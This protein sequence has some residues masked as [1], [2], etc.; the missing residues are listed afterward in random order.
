MEKHAC[1]V[2]WIC[3]IYT[4]TTAR[5]HLVDA[6]TAICTPAQAARIV[7]A[8][9][10]YIVDGANDRPVPFENMTPNLQSEVDRLRAERDRAIDLAQQ[11]VQ[12]MQ[13][14]LDSLRNGKATHLDARPDPA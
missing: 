12:Q 8:L 13:F 1:R 6:L 2:Q 11:T 3:G 9:D 14:A 7:D 4:G 5:D 10:T